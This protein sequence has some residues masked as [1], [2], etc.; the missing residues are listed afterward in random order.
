M[1]LQLFAPCPVEMQSECFR[2][3]YQSFCIEHEWEP[4]NSTGIEY[5]TKDGWSQFVLIVEDGKPVATCRVTPLPKHKDG[6]E[7]SRV[8]IVN[9]CVDRRTARKML[10]EGITTISRKMGIKHWFALMEPRFIKLNKM[11]GLAWEI[12]GPL[13]EHHGKRYPV[14]MKAPLL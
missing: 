2:V 12:V 9:A 6:A 7:I 1:T 13:I 14:Y 5:E 8:A 4:K 10:V 11:Y 3:R